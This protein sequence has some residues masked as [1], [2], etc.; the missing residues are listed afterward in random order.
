M[1]E[2]LEEINEQEEDEEAEKPKKII[3]DDVISSD[4]DKDEQD[5]TDYSPQE[6]AAED[7]MRNIEE[8]M[9]KLCMFNEKLI[10]SDQKTDEKVGE[11]RANVTQVRRQGEDHIQVIVENNARHD[12]DGDVTTMGNSLEC[13]LDART[14]RLIE[15]ELTQWVKSSSSPRRNMRKHVITKFDDDTK[16]FVVERETTEAGE[17]KRAKWRHQIPNPQLMLTEGSN[18][19]LQRL[20]MRYDL[21]QDVAFCK[22]DPD[23]GELCR[24]LYKP[25]PA[26]KQVISGCDVRVSGIERTIASPP[27]VLPSMWQSYF[28][29]DGQM[30]ALIQIGSQLVAQAQFVPVLIERETKEEKPCFPKKAINIDEDMEMVSRFTDRTEQLQQDHLSY[31]R[32]HPEVRD[33]ISDFFQFMLIRQPDDVVAAAAGY[34]S[35][36]SRHVDGNAKDGDKVTALRRH[37]IELDTKLSSTS[38][39]SD[40]QPPSYPF[41]V[42]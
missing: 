5:D 31:M 38:N 37:D 8:E 26:R 27:V 22:I 39:T 25:L 28:M 20:M 24:V 34:F 6:K 21:S 7:F 29:P 10:T 30:T 1:S 35:T 18:V 23:S 11:Y 4:D 40:K 9:I 36:F 19:V 14:L 2:N 33:I 3:I 13:Y 17:L 16:K 15:Q 41:A 42:V 12:V 32:H